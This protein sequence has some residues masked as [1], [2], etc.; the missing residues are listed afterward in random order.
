MAYSHPVRW[1]DPPQQHME[2]NC[3]FCIA[4]QRHRALCWV[5]E[6]HQ[7]PAVTPH[8]RHN[9]MMMSLGAEREEVGST[10]IVLPGDT[11]ALLGNFC[12]VA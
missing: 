12:V 3:H 5:K 9:P 8:G 2:S 6:F 10:M 11:G 7:D 1:V 4:V